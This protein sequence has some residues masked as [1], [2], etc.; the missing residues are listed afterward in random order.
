MAPP[1]CSNEDGNP[2]AVNVYWVD[3]GIQVSLC[4]TCMVPYLAQ[5]LS[6]LTGVQL[7]AIAAV[8]LG[9]PDPTPP[10]RRNGRTPAASSAPPT[11]TAGAPAETTTEPAS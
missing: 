10:T 7:D 8:I 1:L 11:A 2:A 4:D 9:E 6:E 5:A 3:D